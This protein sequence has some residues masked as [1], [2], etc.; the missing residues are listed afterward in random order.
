MQAWIYRGAFQGG[1][2]K[3]SVPPRDRT[4]KAGK[5]VSKALAEVVKLLG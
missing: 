5:S 4:A 3:F 2:P 1:T